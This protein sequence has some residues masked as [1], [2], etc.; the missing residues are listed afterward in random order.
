MFKISDLGRKDIINVSDGVKLG[1]VKD[2]HLDLDSGA[3]KAIVLQGPKKYFRLFGAGQDVVVSWEKV[4]K[5]GQ[6]A[7]LVE[8]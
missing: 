1:A 6:D 3:V 8:I 7:V 4:K 5:V 2:M